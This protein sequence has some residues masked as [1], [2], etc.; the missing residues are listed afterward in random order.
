MPSI[1]L[2]EAKAPLIL[3]LDLGTSSFR[4]LTYDADARGVIGSEEQIPH[5]PTTTA[6]G[7]VEA[8]AADLFDLLIRCVDGA[9]HRLG[10]RK[11]DI[12]AVS[13]S[14]FWHSLM[15][16]G[17]DGEPVTPLFLWA[18]TRSG[19]VIKEL[20]ARLDSAEVHRRTGCLL[21][22][23]YWPAKLRWLKAVSPDAFSR[24]HRVLSFAEYAAER[25]HGDPRVSIS[26]ASGTGLM[27]V[28]TC[29]W[30]EGML[31]ALD[32]R[33]EQFPELMD[34]NEPLAPLQP[35]YAERWP[36]LAG[37]PWFPAAGDGACAN[38][39]SGAVRGDRI[40]LTLGTSGALRI[41]C[42]DGGLTIP[43]GI[44]AYRLDRT[45]Y[46]VGGSLSNG[47]NVLAWLGK[48]LSVE[49]TDD[50]MEDAGRIGADSHGL[51]LLPFI[52]G[53]RAPGWNDETSGVL[54][55]LKLATRPEHVIRASMEAVAYRFARVYDHL[56]PLADKNHEIV[57]NGGA[58]LRSPAWLQIVAD[59]LGHEVR[60][61][62][63]E[64]EVSGRGAAIIGLVASGQLSSFDAAPDPSEGQPVYRWDSDNHQRYRAALS[65]QRQLEAILFPNGSA[66]DRITG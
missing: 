11:E 20:R 6:D 34:I 48:M 45:H 56:C 49:F 46:V 65:R 22:S 32:L 14:C 61:L 42:T 17:P 13:A 59:T 66:W 30:D 55:G 63:A 37:I 43:P 47:G 19:V 41:I 24:A 58:I 15:G 38:V 18:D 25:V 39:G 50:A 54:A 31:Q 28:H 27:D 2:E 35:R 44:W 57:A 29:S 12:A 8:D 26:M 40:A 5:S 60:T 9:L 33:A 7:G 1:S 21:H 52:A 62:H 3:A 53:E 10:R 64:A 51:T 36:S 16:V 4:A 23:S